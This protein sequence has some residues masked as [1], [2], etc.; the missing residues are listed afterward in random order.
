[1]KTILFQNNSIESIDHYINQ[2]EAYFFNLFTDTGIFSEANIRENYVR[3]AK[4]RRND[5][6]D[7]IVQRLSPNSILGRTPENTLFL[8]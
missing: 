4:N 2:Y 1:M 7:R 3:E 5:I 6:F 8:P